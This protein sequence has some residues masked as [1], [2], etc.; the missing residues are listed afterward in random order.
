MNSALVIEEKYT[1][2]QLFNRFIF[3]TGT[4]LYNL[5]SPDSA[6]DKW[7]LIYLMPSSIKVQNPYH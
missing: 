4:F 7:N 1:H 6:R 5:I 3:Q 2:I